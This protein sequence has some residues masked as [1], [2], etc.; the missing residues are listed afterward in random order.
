MRSGEA[1]LAEQNLEGSESVMGSGVQLTTA[2]AARNKVQTG[3]RWA[4][5]AQI[6]QTNVIQLF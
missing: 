1:A 5:D 6:T 4:A 3:R 2:M